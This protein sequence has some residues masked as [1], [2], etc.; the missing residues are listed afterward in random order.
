MAVS[1]SSSAMSLAN[2][3]HAFVFTR[4]GKRTPVSSFRF[5]Y[6]Q[7]GTIMEIISVEIT[8]FGWNI[9]FH[10]KIAMPDFIKFKQK[11]FRTKCIH[12]EKSRRQ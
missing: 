9:Q 8:K 4:Y 12:I 1:G 11:T 6:I 5:F 3:R 10:Y 7:I 2:L